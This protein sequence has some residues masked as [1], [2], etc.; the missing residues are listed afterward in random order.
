MQRGK[1]SSIALIDYDYCETWRTSS[2][3]QEKEDDACN[4][5]QGSNKGTLLPPFP[6]SIPKTHMSMTSLVFVHTWTTPHLAPWHHCTI[7]RQYNRHTSNTQATNDD[8]EAQS[9]KSLVL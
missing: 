6:Q 5:D 4:K 2:P 8:L 9:A 1:W 3:N 7:N